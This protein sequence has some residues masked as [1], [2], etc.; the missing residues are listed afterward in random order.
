MPGKRIV[1]PEF[2]HEAPLV[3]AAQDGNQRAVEHLLLGHEPVRGII[4]SLKRQLDP[5]GR[6]GEDLECVARLGVLEALRSFCFDGGARFSSYAWYFVRGAMLTA[7]YG[8]SARNPRRHSQVTLVA[9][10]Q[11]TRAA[12]DREVGYEQELLQNDPDYGSDPGYAAIEHGDSLAA[13]RGFVEALPANQLVITT[14]IFWANQ[15]HSQVAEMLGV[16]RPA[17][18]RTLKRVTARAQKEL[19]REDFALAA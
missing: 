12:D 6:S 9:L 19:A 3:R 1:P 2:R 15:T 14:E 7:L 18:S 10:E 17:I 8:A 16:S 4:G 11:P 13:V 5:Q